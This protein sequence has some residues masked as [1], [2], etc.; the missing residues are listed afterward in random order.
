MSCVAG[1]AYFFPPFSVFGEPFVYLPLD[2]SYNDYY[3]DYSPSGGV[4]SLNTFITGRVGQAMSFNAASY[5]T[6]SLMPSTLWQGASTTVC[7]FKRILGIC[8]DSI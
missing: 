6:W 3:G 5:L 8:T 2:G 7:A 1:G 4:G